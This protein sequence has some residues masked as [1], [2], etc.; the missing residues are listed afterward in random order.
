LGQLLLSASGVETPFPNPVSVTNSTAMFF[1]AHQA[2]PVV[3]IEATQPAIEPTAND[4]GQIGTFN[5][6]DEVSATDNVTVSYSIS[7]TATNGVDYVTIVNTVS[8]PANQNYVNIQIVPIAVGITPD[9]SIV[10]TIAQNTNYLID[11]SYYYA[12]NVLYADPDLYPTAFGDNEHVC[13]NS[14]GGFYV[15]VNNPSGLTP[16]YAVVTNVTHG[17]VSIDSSGWVTYTPAI[18]FEG[19]D[20]FAYTATSGGY[21]SAP[22]VVTIIVSDPVT[23]SAAQAQTCRNTNTSVTVPLSYYD[24]C[25]E[26]LT[27]SIVVNPT[28]GRVSLS[29]SG[30]TY[31]PTGTSF[32]GTV[33]M[34]RFR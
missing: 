19:I 4:P 25:S 29:G 26:S 18:S 3:G 11:P 28:H 2:Y 20:S 6:Y 21:S 15:N 31:T 32:T 10:L 9:K 30:C 14:L 23:A 12:S 24:V 13:P 27:C 34:G 17:T 16:S 1:K 22:A 33:R 8:I 5:V 7:G